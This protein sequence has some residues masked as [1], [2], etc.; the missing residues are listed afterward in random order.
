MY[1]VYTF[2]ICVAKFNYNYKISHMETQIA[3]I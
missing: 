3:R 2:I 1:Y